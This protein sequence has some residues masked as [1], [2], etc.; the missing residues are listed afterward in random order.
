MTAGPPERAEPAGDQPL[1]GDEEAREARVADVLERVRAGVRQRQAEV[2]AAGAGSEEAQHKLL[3]LKTREYVQE[4]LCVSPRPVVG[5]LLVFSRKAVFHLFLK[6]VVRPL[7]EQ[8]NLY[9]QTVSRLLQE[10]LGAEERTE[11][12]LRETE[13]RLAALEKRQEAAGE[14]PG[15]PTDRSS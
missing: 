9:N 14:G 8:Q 10:I 7:L 1:A 6:W 15:R 11:R 3:E 12:R 2:S 4:P 5:R 13:A